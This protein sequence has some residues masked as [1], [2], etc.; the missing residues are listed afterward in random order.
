MEEATVPEIQRTALATAV[1]YLKSLPLDINVLHFDFLD[2]PSVRYSKSPCYNLCNTIVGVADPTV[3][4]SDFISKSSGSVRR[5]R[6][7][8]VSS[9]RRRGNL[10]LSADSS[11]SSAPVADSSA[12]GRASTAVYSRMPG[13]RRGHPADGAPPRQAAAGP[14]P[15]PGARRGGRDRLSRSRLLRLRDAYSRVGVRRQQVLH[16]LRDQPSTLLSKRRCWCNV[17]PSL[18]V[19]L[20]LVAWCR[21]RRLLSPVYLYAFSDAEVLSSS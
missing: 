8:P 6:A 21:R 4:N 11:D 13:R 16:W 1:L 18:A 15:G 19:E 5:V 3:S 14:Q 9:S 2:A 12:R 7:F 17:C 20:G 10:G